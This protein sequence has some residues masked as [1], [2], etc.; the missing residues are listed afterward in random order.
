MIS[1]NS[2]APKR[3]LLYVQ[4]AVAA[5]F[6]TTQAINV[7]FRFETSI[8]TVTCDEKQHGTYRCVNVFNVVSVVITQQIWERVHVVIRSQGKNLCFKL[9]SQIE[10]PSNSERCSSLL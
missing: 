8:A 9:N 7:Q 2:L 6:I 10:F 3:P 5:T 1:Y 4:P